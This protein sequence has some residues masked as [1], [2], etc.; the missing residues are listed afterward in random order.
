MGV[1]DNYDCE[2]QMS[3]FDLQNETK[4]KSIEQLHKE[5]PWIRLCHGHDNECFEHPENGICE[6]YYKCSK[7][8]EYKTVNSYYLEKMNGRE[9][10]TNP[11]DGCRIICD[12]NKADVD[13][14]IRKTNEY[15]GF[16]EE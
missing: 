16:S 4:S 6:S 11:V 15:F 5:K 12:G 8:M 14:L 2:G 13:E 3:I 7:R 10:L 1:F 9:T